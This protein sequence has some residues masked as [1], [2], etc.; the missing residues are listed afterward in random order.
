MPRLHHA[1]DTLL[2]AAQQHV[3]FA[4]TSMAEPLSAFHHQKY[5]FASMEHLLTWPLYRMKH[6]DCARLIDQQHAMFRPSA[7]A[8]YDNALPSTFI[9]RVADPTRLIQG[10]RGKGLLLDATKSSSTSRSSALL[11]LRHRPPRPRPRLT[12]LSRPRSLC[13]RRASPSALY[14]PPH[15]PVSHSRSCRGGAWEAPSDCSF[16]PILSPCQCRRRWG[17]PAKTSE[18]R[19]GEHGLQ[20]TSTRRT[21]A[22]KPPRGSQTIASQRPQMVVA[23]VLGLQPALGTPGDTKPGM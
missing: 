14:Q 20:I 3:R 1:R 7:S 13:P 22:E 19:K 4:I 11:H 23:V 6:C 8:A 21:D 17:A 12:G 5:N 18:Q 16:P 9:H 2:S 10:M 15:C